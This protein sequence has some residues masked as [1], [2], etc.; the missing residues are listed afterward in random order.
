MSEKLMLIDGNSIVNRAFYGVPDLTNRDGQH[1]N[2]IYG[3]L[4]ILFR[5][6]DDESP[7]YVLVA[8][9][10]KAPTFRHEMYAEYKGTR[11]GMPDELAE[12][13]PVLKD[14]LKS[15]QIAIYSQA[16][17]EADD[18][19]GT[20]ATEGKKAGLTVTVVSGDRDLLQLV[21]DD[22]R[23]LQPKTKGGKTEVLDYDKSAV[24]RD[25]HVTPSQIVDLKGLMGDS[26]DNIPGV[27]GVG[28]K[29]AIKL[30]DVYGTVE[31]V[32]KHADEIEN[33]R[34][35]NNI[36]AHPE[37]A[38]LSKK[39]AT[40]KRDC[41]LEIRPTDCEVGDIFN[42]EAHK[43]I[44]KLEFK[45]ILARFEQGVGG[46]DINLDGLIISDSAKDLSTFLDTITK[47]EVL[48]IH[49]VLR[50]EG[51]A[52]DASG[53]M[54]LFSPEV[55]MSG[56]V[57]IAIAAGD[58]KLA[59]FEIGDKLSEAE[60]TEQLTTKAQKG[61][62]LVANDLKSVLSFFPD[63]TPEQ[64]FDTNLAAYLVRPID[65]SFSEEDIATAYLGMS[66]GT[67][68]QEFGKKTVSVA[69]REDRDAFIRYMAG[70]ALVNAK[71]Y[72]YFAKELKKIKS[73]K[74]YYEI[75]MPLVFVL[76]DMEQ[77][78]IRIEREALRAYGKRLGERIDELEQE[79]YKNAG[80][81]F[82]INS[83]KQLGV[84]LF[85]KKRLPYGKKT[86]TGYSTSAEVLEKLRLED[87]I[88]EMILEYRQL[89]KLKSTYADGLDGFIDADGR[90]RTTFHQ[91]ITAT[92]RLSSTEPN[93]Q[94]IPIRMELGREIRRVFIPEDGYTF[95]DADYSQIELRV[96]AHLSG[97]ERLI[98]AYRQDADIHRIT[99]SQ[100]FHTPFE[101]VTP[102]QRRNA[103][104]VNFGIVYGISGFGLSRDLD[105][106][107]KQAKQYIEDYFATY[108]GVHAFME[109]LVEDG[110]KQGYV[111]SMFGRR[112]PIPE[113]SSKNFMQRQF[114]ERVAMNSPIQGTAAD[115]IKIAMIRV[116]ER[117]KREGLKS[118]LILQIHDELLIETALDEK[119]QVK[120][121]LSEEMTGACELAVPLIAEVGQGDNWEEAH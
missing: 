97:D 117:L 4:N 76:Y 119:E 64:C 73:D 92:G 23:I 86:K 48:A 79:I 20:M 32:L 51:A 6:L 7:R 33:T 46:H 30:L 90:I 82:N 17:I 56:L 31:E 106:T 111:A 2:A 61:S 47:K 12:Q 85:E 26:S 40:I 121:I 116:W 22:I 100:V 45:S 89:T 62:R 99:A 87:P 91:N 107:Q 52:A 96:L 74:L 109:K 54:T 112:R 53:Q 115:I 25:F 42:D 16:G 37:M 113:L 77:Y 104:A 103:K 3:F 70:C 114:G 94:N 21:E 57:A 14:V 95:L 10:E 83:P 8:F 60:V 58:D 29:T 55:N 15:M 63:L 67:Y 38:T 68:A 44:E 81:E 18:I 1:T 93:L 43:Q 35:R 34:A 65:K 24:I 11:K 78:G 120:R 13:M 39:L 66:I 105:I 108:P 80:E 71:A 41:K 75:E 72:E 27:P 98:E 9:D 118:R 5:L 101:E 19:L 88:V 59:F 28:E 49:P 69:F 102:L 36:Q 50:E 84:I 110:K